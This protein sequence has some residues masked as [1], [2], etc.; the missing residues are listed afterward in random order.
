M[1]LI[2]QIDRGLRKVTAHEKLRIAFGDGVA[3]LERY[4]S[5]TE[6]I[7]VGSL[8]SPEEA[9]SVYDV[10]AY[11]TKVRVRVTVNRDGRSLMQFEEI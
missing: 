5:H 8:V 7:C 3:L 9:L 11:D 10:T 1:E 4:I 6:A 2:N